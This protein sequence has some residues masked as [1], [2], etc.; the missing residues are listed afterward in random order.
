MTTTKTRKKQRS[1]KIDVVKRKSNRDDIYYCSYRSIIIENI[2][3]AIFEGK[4]KNFECNKCT[5]TKSL[6][7]DITII[8]NREVLGIT[9]RSI[10]GIVITFTIKKNSEEVIISDEKILISI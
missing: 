2:Y 6:S 9:M 8:L 7:M 5:Y 4:I 1:L 3:K 10:N